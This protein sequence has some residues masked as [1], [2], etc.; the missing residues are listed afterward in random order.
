[1]N[2]QSILGD[3]DEQGFSIVPDVLTRAKAAK[4]TARLW[5][6]SEELQSRGTAVFR[7]DIDQNASNVRIFDLP[8]HDS[9]FVDLLTRPEICSLIAEALGGDI[10]LSNFTANIARPGARPM[11]VHSDQALSLPEPWL[12][13]WVLNVIW[14]LDDICEANGATRYV[15]GSH[16]FQTM[17]ELPADID[18]ASRPFEAAAGSIIFMDGRLWHSSGS[19][20]TADCDRPLLFG[21]YARAFIRPQVNWH[22]VLRPEVIAALDARQRQ[23]FGFGQFANS[24]GLQLVLQD[25]PQ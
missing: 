12:E 23:L 15:P 19:N 3:L 10:M 1:M 24:H 6:I 20:V 11:K 8:E 2:G 4:L 14:C 25:P 17:D 18:T 22:E 9:A 7:P 16:K 5:E 21:Y 13:S